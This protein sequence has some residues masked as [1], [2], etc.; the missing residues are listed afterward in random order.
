MEAMTWSQK[1]ADRLKALIGMFRRGRSAGHPANAT[2]KRAD[3]VRDT[4]PEA[5]P[6]DTI[7]PLW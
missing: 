5:E 6:P 3:R 4:K 2:A 7:Y 1:L